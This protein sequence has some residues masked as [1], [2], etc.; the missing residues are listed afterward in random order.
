[1]DY[2]VRRKF[3]QVVI[4]KVVSIQTISAINTGDKSGDI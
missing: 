2:I 3:D 1:M 4:D